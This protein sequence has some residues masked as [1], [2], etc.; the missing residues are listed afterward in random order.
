MLDL[1]TAAIPDSQA[2]GRIHGRDFIV[3]RAILQSGSLTLRAGRNGTVEFGVIINFGGAQPESLAGQSL[4]IT[5]NVDRAAGIMLR[6]KDGDQQSKVT[7][8]NGYALR[9]NFGRLSGNHFTGKIYLCAP[10]ETK[11]YVAGTFIVDIRRPKPR[12]Q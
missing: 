11:S 9:L 6:W 5:T 7:I 2:A 4:N 3:E 8:T 1:E 10:D 12:Q